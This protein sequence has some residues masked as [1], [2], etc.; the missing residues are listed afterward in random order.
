[1]KIKNSIYNQ[2]LSIQT[3]HFEIGG[4][5]GGSNSIITKFV[6]DKNKITEDKF[7]YIPNIDYLNSILEKW[8]ADGIEFYGIFHTHPVGQVTL[9]NDDIVSIKNIMMA[10]PESIEMLYFP[11]VI[12]NDTV[13]PYVAKRENN[14]INIYL[15][16]LYIIDSKEV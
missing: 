7:M 2:I 8:Y 9:S 1:M 5:F 10:L 6:L 15:D 13:Y 3:A 16:D 12:Q 14:K 11:I 4:I